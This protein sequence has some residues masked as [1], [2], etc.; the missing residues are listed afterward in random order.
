M[1]ERQQLTKITFVTDHDTG[2]YHIGE[3]DGIFS[4][5]Q[6][7]DFYRRFGDKGREELVSHLGFLQ[8]QAYKAWFE[9]QSQCQ[10]LGDASAEGN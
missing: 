10:E 3:V 2:M 6:L 7:V 9:Y 5:D 1:P 8:H 4:E